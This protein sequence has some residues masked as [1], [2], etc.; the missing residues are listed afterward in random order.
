VRPVVWLNCAVSHDGFLAAPDGSPVKLSDPTDLRR[1]HEMRAEADAILVGIQTILN[2]D[3]SLQVKPE[4]AS[5]E[6]PI[7]VVLDTHLR[8]PPSARVLG[9]E[10][11]LYTARDG[12]IAGAEMVHARATTAGVDLNDVLGDLAERG[13]KTLMVEGGGAVL[14]SFISQ[15][16]WDRATVFIA[17][18]NLRAGPV[19]PLEQLASAHLVEEVKRGAGVLRTYVREAPTQ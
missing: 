6:S 19:G 15:G 3:P 9:D 8:T 4:Y 16:L 1:V 12:R 13:I 2:D 17:K 18:K 14:E 7:R 10:T 5:G 11:L